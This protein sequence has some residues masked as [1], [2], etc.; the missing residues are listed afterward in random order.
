LVSCIVKDRI[1]LKTGRSGECVN[2][3]EKIGDRGMEKKIALRGFIMI[4]A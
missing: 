1:C 2:L 4:R 3:N